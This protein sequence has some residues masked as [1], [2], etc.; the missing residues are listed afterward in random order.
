M[1]AV[2]LNDN[3]NKLIGEEK[4]SRISKGLYKVMSR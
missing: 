1:T 4:I 2:A 3:L